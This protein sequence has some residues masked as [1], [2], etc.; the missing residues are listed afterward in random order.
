MAQDAPKAEAPR[1]AT[2]HQLTCALREREGQ[3]ACITTDSANVIG[4][5]QQQKQLLSLRQGCEKLH[6]ELQLEQHR[7]RCARPPTARPWPSA[8]E[9]CTALSTPRW[10]GD[11]QHCLT[12][13]D[14]I[15]RQQTVELSLL[16]LPRPSLWWCCFYPQAPLISIVEKQ[17]PDLVI[18]FESS[19]EEA[20]AEGK[21]A[22]GRSSISPQR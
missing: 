16:E 12:I 4:S 15:K 2:R 20:E 22:R 9:R 14:M 10:R 17:V 8:G 5:D 13:S 21:S 6:H 19:A 1:R 3:S 11:T 7:C 18:E